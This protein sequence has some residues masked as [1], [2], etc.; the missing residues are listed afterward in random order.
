MVT[1]GTGA[2]ITVHH[3]GEDRFR[4][5]VRGHTVLVDQPFDAGGEDT[6]PTPTELLVTSLASCVAFF[7]RRYLARHGIGTEGMA[8]AA[9][10]EMASRPSRV[11]AIRIEVTTPPGLPPENRKPLLAVANGCTV[12]NTLAG[13][14]PVSVGLAE[15]A[16]MGR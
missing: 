2:P 1:M 11:G 16:R 5:D 14:V 10:Y 7:V 9:W 8:V 13:S 4:I 15:P 6:A 3:Q 12:H